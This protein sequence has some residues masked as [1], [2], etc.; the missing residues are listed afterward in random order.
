MPLS[1]GGMPQVA[2][3]RVENLINFHDLY[4]IEYREIAWSFVVQ[5]NKIKNLLGDKF[6]SLGWIDKEEI[7]DHFQEIIERINPDIIHMEEIPEKFIFG[8]RKEHA[9]LAL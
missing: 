5:R 7:R 2:L 8:M 1:T 9:E 4:L 6:I 3:K